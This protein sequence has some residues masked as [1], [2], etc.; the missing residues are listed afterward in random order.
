MIVTA[1]ISAIVALVTVFFDRRNKKE[2]TESA[3]EKFHAEQVLA[4]RE[5]LSREWQQLREYQS[6]Q[7]EMARQR[8]RELEAIILAKDQEL[9]A[10]EQMMRELREHILKQSQP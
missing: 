1:L 6:N 9:A 2:I 3:E 8:A 7:L 10:K 4:E 5:A